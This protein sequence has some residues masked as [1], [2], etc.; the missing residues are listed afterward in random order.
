MNDDGWTVYLYDEH[1]FPK[2]VKENVSEWT[3]W[4]EM[5]VL[6]R[7]GARRVWRENRKDI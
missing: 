2:I 3:S 5:D 4:H 6:R 1:G 7:A